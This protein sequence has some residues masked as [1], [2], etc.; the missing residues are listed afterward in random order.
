ML[1]VYT[2]VVISSQGTLSDEVIVHVNVLGQNVKD[3]VPTHVD[4]THIFT[5]EENRIRDGNAQILQ[6]YF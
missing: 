4:T 2:C 5:V 6:D 3:W 1:V